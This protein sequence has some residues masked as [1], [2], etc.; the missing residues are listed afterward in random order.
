[1][2]RLS[3]EERGPSVLDQRHRAVMTF[4]YKF[5]YHF[6]AGTVTMLASSRPF[7]ATTGVDNNGDGA[8]ND[9]PVINGAVVGKSAFRGTPT[10]DVGL[11]VE[12]RIRLS[13]RFAI[14][15]RLEGFNLT[16]HGNYLGRGVTT[17]GDATTPAT[18]FGQFVAVGA[19]TNA[20]P[21]F[22][23][24]DPPRMVQLQARFIF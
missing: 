3:E 23:N 16:N 13:E 22:A 1:M 12:N 2:S 19:A 11:F 14:L 7:N 15:L 18:T 4:S 17:Y 21:A 6:T 5:P 20:I 10:T 8:N 24:I 9:R